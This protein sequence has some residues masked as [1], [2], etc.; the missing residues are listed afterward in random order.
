MSRA[1]RRDGSERVGKLER[2]P[3]VEDARA[4]MEGGGIVAVEESLIKEVRCTFERI[5]QSKGIS[6]LLDI[7]RSLWL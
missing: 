5:D 4:W 6:D 2:I 1:E 3:M 7:W